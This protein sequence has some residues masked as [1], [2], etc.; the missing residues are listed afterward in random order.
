M[1]RSTLSVAIITLN[2][3]DNLARTLN[4]A[5]QNFVYLLDAQ[6]RNQEGQ[7]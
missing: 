3:E 5:S 6:R 2:E 1:P 4:A 7:G